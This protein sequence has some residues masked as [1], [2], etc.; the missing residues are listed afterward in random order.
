MTNEGGN[1]GTKEGLSIRG[2]RALKQKLAIVDEMIDKAIAERTNAIE[3]VE[4]QLTM[5]KQQRQDIEAELRVGINARPRKDV[6]VFDE[7]Q[8]T[9]EPEPPRGRGPAI[10]TNGGRGA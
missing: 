1:V 10:L 9:A 6:V 5:L 2:E 3:K 7:E 8:A 4:A